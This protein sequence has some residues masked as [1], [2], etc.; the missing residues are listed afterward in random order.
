LLSII[1]AAVADIIQLTIWKEPSPYH[2]SILTGQ[3]W[4][5]VPTLLTGHPE[6]IHCELRMHVEVSSQLIS[7]L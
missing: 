5:E 7:E 3:G 1:L 6:C 4:D 2:T